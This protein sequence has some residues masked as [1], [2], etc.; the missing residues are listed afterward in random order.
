MIKLSEHR[1]ALVN[2][3]DTIKSLD[4]IRELIRMHTSNE[5]QDYPIS[6]TIN[7]IPIQFSKSI[8]LE[9]LNTQQKK[10]VEYLLTLGIEA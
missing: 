4:R 9:A 1:A 10:V 7:K 6:A 2:L 8:I 5:L 3:E